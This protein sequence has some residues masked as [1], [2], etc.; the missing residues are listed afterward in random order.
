MLPQFSAWFLSELEHCFLQSQRKTGSSWTMLRR[1]WSFWQL[2]TIQLQLMGYVYWMKHSA[3]QT[4][5]D[6]WFFYLIKWNTPQIEHLKITDFLSFGW[7]QDVNVVYL[8]QELL[9]V[10]PSISS[11]ILPEVMSR[12]SSRVFARLIREA[13]L[14]SDFSYFRREIANSYF[15]LFCKQYITDDDRTHRRLYS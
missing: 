4:S 7:C 6:Y 11:K 3:N 14:W 13:F 12:L 2:G 5:K 1:L 9:P 15:S 10:L 8:V